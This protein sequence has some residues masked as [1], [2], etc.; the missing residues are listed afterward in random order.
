MRDVLP[1]PPPPRTM[2]SEPSLGQ[3]LQKQLAEHLGCTY[4]SVGFSFSGSWTARIFLLEQGR[5]AVVQLP[6]EVT[7]TAHTGGGGHL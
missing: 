4:L 3:C 6:L 2:H 7:R 1:C 5:T